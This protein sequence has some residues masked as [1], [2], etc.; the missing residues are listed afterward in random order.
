MTSL[1]IFNIVAKTSHPDNSSFEGP[2]AEA[3]ADRETGR[4]LSRGALSGSRPSRVVMPPTSCYTQIQRMQIRADNDNNR[5][6][7]RS[8]NK[9]RVSRQVLESSEHRLDALLIHRTC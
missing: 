2:T 9:F 8:D 4:L 5:K 7:S 3:E 1:R 6:S